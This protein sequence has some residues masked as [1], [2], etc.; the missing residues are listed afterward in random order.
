M[1]SGVQ[2]GKDKAAADSRQQQ[3]ESSRDR[4]EVAVLVLLFAIVFP[5]WAAAAFLG[6]SETI[7]RLVSFCVMRAWR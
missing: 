1:R 4:S 5:Y 2:K 6:L 7:P 3:G